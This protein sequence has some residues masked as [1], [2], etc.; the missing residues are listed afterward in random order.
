MKNKLLL[1]CAAMLVGCSLFAQDFTVNGI[2]YSVLNS[3]A[4]T[5]TTAE[6]TG[7]NSRINSDLVGDIEIPEKV[8]YNNT[9]YTVTQIGRFSFNYAQEITSVKL[10]ETITTLRQSA[11]A[12]CTKLAEI[13]LPDGITTIDRYALESTSITQLTIPKGLTDIDEYAFA[14]MSHLNNIII[15]D[16]V[17]TIGKDAFSTCTFVKTIV[18]GDGVTQIGE[19]AFNGCRATTLIIGKNVNYIGNMAFNNCLFLQTIISLN[20]V[21]PTT[22][23][24]T[25]G[26][27]Y[28]FP[29]EGETYSNAGHVLYV[30]EGSEAAYKNQPGWRKFAYIEPYV[31]DEDEEP[32][33][34]DEPGTMLSASKYVFIKL[35]E[36]LD[37]AQIFNLRTVSY[38]ETNNSKV[39]AL[40][41][42]SETLQPEDMG[43]VTGAQYGEAV[44]GA[45]NVYGELLA[46][47]GVFVCPSLTVVY[48]DGATTEHLVVHNSPLNVALR[49]SSRWQISSVT[50]DETD[51]TDKVAP[52]SGLYKSELPVKANTV[53]TVVGK[54]TSEPVTGAQS[55]V[56]DSSL[57]VTVAG[58]TVS[59]LGDMENKTVVV[60][61]ALGQLVASRRTPS[62][63]LPEAGVYVIKVGDDTFRVAVR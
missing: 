55:V 22:Q 48:P 9:E 33:Q 4:R 49:P 43:K 5:V 26:S 19:Y 3:A 25:S 16:H 18:I 12:K 61:N 57:R 45:Y 32:E 15:P 35:G 47:L 14:S 6:G 44:V 21:P 29:M 40:P 56:A 46:T 13:N 53:L 39:A 27:Y 10:P 41:E 37:M 51:V 8:V 30:P 59:I 36:T 23:P 58:R 42:E 1:T 34:P 50:H 62:V 2:K 17:K 54:E 38:Y 28:T 11:F 7:N 31:P 60:Y 20:P 24:W 63:V 52:L